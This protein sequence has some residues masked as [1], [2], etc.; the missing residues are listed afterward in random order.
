MSNQQELYSRVAR[1]A[2]Y[3]RTLQSLASRRKINPYQ[4]AFAGAEYLELVRD[5]VQDLDAALAKIYDSILNAPLDGPAHFSRENTW[6][7]GGPT[8]SWGGSMAKDA[9]IQAANYFGFDNVMYVYGPHTEEMFEIHKNCRKIIC[10]LGG[11]CRTEGAQQLGD[12]EEAE[13]L[14]R[15]SLK[16]PNIVGGVIDDM[17]GNC[18][19]RYSRKLYIEMHKALKAHNPKLESYSVV[20]THELDSPMLQAFR[21][22]EFPDR[23]ILWTW[24]KNDLPGLEMNVEKTRHLFPGRK[25]MM[26]L[27]MFDY[28]LT[29]LPNDLPS[30][31][32]QLEMS[33]RLLK[34]NKIHDIVILGDR[35]IH[36]CPAVAEYIREF[37]KK[38]FAAQCNS[39]GA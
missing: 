37:F 38:E 6:V 16:Y 19:T 11:N 27:F 5:N 21:D 31:A 35:E 32:F 28:G 36:K 34:Q 24:N 23:I 30:I 20:Y 39:Q 17:I 14:S 33:R 22:V 29:V 18:G 26:G 7:W 9:S 4:D 8:P 10:H 3:Q 12:V 15:M 1:A 13:N 25:I 2:Q